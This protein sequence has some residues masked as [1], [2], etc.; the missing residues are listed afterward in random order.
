MI[1]ACIGRKGGIGKS[2]VSIHLAY[3]LNQVTP[4]LLIDD[5]QNRSSLAWSRRGS[6]PFQV[7]PERQASVHARKYESIVADTAGKLDRETMQD[8]VESGAE[9]ILLSNT[10]ALSIDVLLPTADELKELGCT[11]FRVLLNSVPPVGNAGSDV[12]R[13]LTERGL[14]MFKSMIRRFSAY[15]KA[16]YLG[17]TVD[18]VKDPYAETAWSD[19]VA[20][21]KEL[22]K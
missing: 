20:L 1:Y 2:T 16:S 15:Q 6:L 19:F 12:H 13:F 8:Y 3:L 14:P 10:D 11:R 7:I 4:T 21:G 22:Q 17:T 18:Q 5:D 9:L